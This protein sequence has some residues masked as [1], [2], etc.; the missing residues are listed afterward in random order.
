M[1]HK[2]DRILGG[3]DSHLRT[4]CQDPGLRTKASGHTVLPPWKKP[5]LNNPDQFPGVKYNSTHLGLTKLWAEFFLNVLT[6]IYIPKTNFYTFT[7]C[8]M[9]L[10]N[11]YYSNY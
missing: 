7:M 8:H 3:E 2:S 4:D 5:V 1:Q 10:H 11:E 6:F 9:L